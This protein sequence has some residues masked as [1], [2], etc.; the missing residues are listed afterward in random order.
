[1]S[2]CPSRL[3]G[4]MAGQTGRVDKKEGGFINGYDRMP[5]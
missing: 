2:D 3:E 5:G 1:M 4:G